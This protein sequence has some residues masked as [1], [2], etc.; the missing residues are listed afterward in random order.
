MSGKLG[1]VAARGKDLNPLF[2]VLNPFYL[3]HLEWPLFLALRLSNTRLLE[4]GEHFL[5]CCCCSKAPSSHPA[6]SPDESPFSFFFLIFLF[7]LMF[8]YLEKERERETEHEWGRGRER[9]GDTE[10]EAGSRL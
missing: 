2:P 9:E 4:E 5:L 1:S 10:L 8:I 7:F 6:W 3:N